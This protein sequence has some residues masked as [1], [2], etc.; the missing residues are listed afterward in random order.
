MSK[1]K[2]P[3]TIFLF[4]MTNR[5]L[6]NLKVMARYH[7]KHGS[8]CL[9][10]FK[11]ACFVTFRCLG[12]HLAF[13]ERSDTSNSFGEKRASWLSAGGGEDPCD[14]LMAL[15]EWRECNFLRST[16]RKDKQNIRRSNIINKVNLIFWAIWKQTENEVIRF[17][18]P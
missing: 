3:S 14:K 8:N 12:S 13:R 2:Q 17:E 10:N 16:Y 7:Q 15:R 4:D 11:T 5:A 1:I 6:P 18:F 9:D